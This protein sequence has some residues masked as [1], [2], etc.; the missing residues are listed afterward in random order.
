M[1][2]IVLTAL[3]IKYFT[4]LFYWKKKNLVVTERNPGKK[5]AYGE[6]CV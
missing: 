4:R 3:F 6:K 1:N 5:T 2:V